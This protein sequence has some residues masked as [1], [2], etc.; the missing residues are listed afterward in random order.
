VKNGKKCYL[1]IKKYFI[2]LASGVIPIKLF[3]YLLKHTFTLLRLRL[4]HFIENILL[5]MLQTLKLN[6]KKL[7]MTVKKT[8]HLCVLV[9]LKITLQNFGSF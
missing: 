3:F 8:G 1:V 7:K 5:T 6:I 2:G 9:V 4:G